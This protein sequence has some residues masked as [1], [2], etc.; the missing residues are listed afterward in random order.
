[1]PCIHSCRWIYFCDNNLV[2]ATSRSW[3]QWARVWTIKGP[4]LSKSLCFLVRTVWRQC[5]LTA[6]ML[7]S[8]DTWCSLQEAPHSLPT[9][10]CWRLPPAPTIR[11]SNRL[12][13]FEVLELQCIAR[14]SHLEQGIKAM[15]EN[16]PC[17]LSLYYS[18]FIGPTNM[19]LTQ[20][21]C[22]H[23]HWLCGISRHICVLSQ[24]ISPSN[25]FSILCLTFL[26]SEA[27]FVYLFVWVCVK[28]C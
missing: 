4:V 22:S 6:A 10:L 2:P 19:T 1:M 5:A 16:K 17:A 7:G 9:N 8:Q 27:I 3:V 14:P 25:S 11:I 24:L 26:E 23:M 28:V 18:L 12:V 13:L 15:R 20:A 21:H